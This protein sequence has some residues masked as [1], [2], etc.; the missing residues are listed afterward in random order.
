MLAAHFARSHRTK[1]PN[2]SSRSTNAPLKHDIK[3]VRV[4]FVYKIDRHQATK[5]PTNGIFGHALANAS[6]YFFD[7][8]LTEHKKRGR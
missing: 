3:A 7:G 6:G 5:Y 1:R 8:L 4:I 2:P